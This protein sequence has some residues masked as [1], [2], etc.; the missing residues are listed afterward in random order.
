MWYVLNK[1]ERIQIRGVSDDIIDDD[2]LPET[3]V[4]IME[5]LVSSFEGVSSTD[6]TYDHISDIGD[7]KQLHFPVAIKYLKSILKPTD[8]CEVSM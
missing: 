2:Q 5:D 8:N 7:N 1:E 3:Q 6:I 4:K